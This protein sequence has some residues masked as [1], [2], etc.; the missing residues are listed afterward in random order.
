MEPSLVLTLIGLLEK[1]GIDLFNT[2]SKLNKEKYDNYILPIWE[3]FKL[4]HEDYKNSYVKYAKWIKED[5][6]LDDLIEEI[7][8]DSIITEDLRSELRNS[9]KILYK[10]DKNKKLFTFFKDISEYFH[11]NDTT[12]GVDDMGNIILFLYSSPFCNWRRA[13]I[14]NKLTDNK[15]TNKLNDNRITNREDEFYRRLCGS[16]FYRRQ[17][18]GERNKY[19]Q[20]NSIYSQISDLQEQYARISEDFNELKRE[21]I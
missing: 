15:I 6:A 10:D 18:E 14:I 21:L 5:S 13:I 1:V 8:Q 11:Q 7:K 20:I 4:I 16:E 2:K 12:I 3:T 19:N 9:I 17:C